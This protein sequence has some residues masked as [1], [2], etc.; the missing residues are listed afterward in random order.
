MLRRHQA[1]WSKSHR[2]CRLTWWSRLA[3]SCSEDWSSTQWKCRSCHLQQEH[4]LQERYHQAQIWLTANRLA[5]RSRDCN[6]HTFDLWLLPGYRLMRRNRA[7]KSRLSSK[8]K[9]HR[10]PKLRFWTLFCRHIRRSCYQRRWIYQEVQAGSRHLT[11][12]ARSFC[13]F[14]VGW[15]SQRNQYRRSSAPRI[16][17]W[18]YLRWRPQ[19]CKV[20][21]LTWKM[22][23]RVAHWSRSTE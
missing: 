16:K 17:I 5:R 15:A 18:E 3:F 19:I 11:R 8:Q 22:L 7:T 4:R 1:R 10:W 2:T 21:L 14:L 13:S 20:W 12:T 6:P 9:A 23:D